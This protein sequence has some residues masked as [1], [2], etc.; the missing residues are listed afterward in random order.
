MRPVL[1]AVRLQ[2]FFLARGAHEASEIAARMKALPAPVRRRQEGDLDLLPDGRARLV[3]FV[4]ERVRED[5]VAEIAAVLLQLAVR[6]RLL[7]ADE[8]AGGAAARAALAE[9]VLHRLHLHVIPV[10]PEAA[11]DA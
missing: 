11:Q 3:L 4:V 1:D 7:A 2:L 10:R 9:P 6:K 8:L 5:L